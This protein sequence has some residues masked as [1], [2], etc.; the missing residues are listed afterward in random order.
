MPHLVATVHSLADKGVGF[1]SLRES[2]DTTSAAGRLVLHMF[3]ALADFERELIRERTRSALAAKK[4][5]GEK[6][7]RSFSLTPA[8]VR[9]A[10][11]MI[12][13]GKGISH[14]ARLFKCDR[15]T[16]YRALNRVCA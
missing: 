11:E 14:V 12:E 16:M 8:Q 3:A 1:R 10:R 2:I 7:G 4:T 6:L 13:A 9:A 15:A 5:R